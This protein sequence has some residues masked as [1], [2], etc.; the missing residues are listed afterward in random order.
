MHAR[1]TPTQQGAL[2]SSRFRTT[3]IGRA[4]VAN[5]E[6]ERPQIRPGCRYLRDLLLICESSAMGFAQLRQLMPPRTLEE[7]LVK[8]LDLGLVEV[9]DRAGT[10]AARNSRRL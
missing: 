2:G 1:V 4:Y 6:F 5:V 8:L 7:S 10:Q 9:V 3:E